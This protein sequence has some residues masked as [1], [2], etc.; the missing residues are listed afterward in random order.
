MP[1][2]SQTPPHAA[3]AGFQERVF[4][5]RAMGEEAVISKEARVFEEIVI[6]KSAA[7]R[8]EVVRDTVRETKADIEDSTTRR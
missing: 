4:E 5:V 1:S 6:R 2:P 8:V 7:D 3:A